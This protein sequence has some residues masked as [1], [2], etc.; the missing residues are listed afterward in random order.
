MQQPLGAGCDV[1]H[2]DQDLDIDN[3]DQGVTRLCGY[4]YNHLTTLV[5]DLTRLGLLPEHDDR[6]RVSA[7]LPAQHRIA[8]SHRGE[9]LQAAPAASGVIRD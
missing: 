4:G 3:E 9:E 7:I 2:C 8:T 1:T 6:G 5:T